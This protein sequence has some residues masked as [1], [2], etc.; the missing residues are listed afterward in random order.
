PDLTRGKFNLGDSALLSTAGLIVDERPISGANNTSPLVINGG[1][2]SINAYTADLEEGSTIDAS[3]GVDVGGTGAITY[4]LGGSVSIRA[5]QDPNP[6]TA[7]LL[8][9]RLAL[10]ATLSAFSGK[11]GGSLSILAPFI[12]VGGTTSNASTLLL[13]PDFFN[14]GGFNSF[15]LAGIGMPNIG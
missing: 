3:G 14:H 13:A 7:S 9:G 15:T 8:G 6:I 10:D 12:Q 4:G 5:G 11:K 1:S 2:I